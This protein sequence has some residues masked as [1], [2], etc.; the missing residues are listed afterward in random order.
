[1]SY[2]LGNSMSRVKRPRSSAASSSTEEPFVYPTEIVMDHTKKG[3]IILNVIFAIF[4]GVFI[5]FPQYC[6]CEPLLVC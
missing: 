3:A 1:M 5:N 4:A 6:S 2:D